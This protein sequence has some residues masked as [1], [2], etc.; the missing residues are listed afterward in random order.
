MRL[1]SRRAGA[2]ALFALTCALA[3]GAPPA[4]A[5]KK[6]EA[7]DPSQASFVD[8][9]RVLSEY[10]KSSAFQKYEKQL[11]DRSAQ[12][13]DEMKFLAD[14][15]FVTDAERKEA[16]EI[17]FK[18]A[19][20]AAEKAR[21]EAILKKS[22]DS[23][24][25]LTD[26]SQKAKPTAAETKRIAD[27]NTMRNETLRSLAREETTR[28]EQ[29]QRMDTELTAQVQDELLKL[30]EKVARE[31]KVPVIYDR[32]AVLFGGNDLTEEVLKKVPK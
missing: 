29:L 6:G 17:K 20:S 21:L 22:A 2:A 23:E 32:R 3:V 12:L 5:A 7:P 8:L 13:G 25:E 31:E 24:K 28:R 27:L 14:L 19:A 26:L 15:R 1:F 11:R 16:V 30:V 10:R 18:P 4:H 9:N